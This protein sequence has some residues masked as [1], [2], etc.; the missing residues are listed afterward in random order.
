MLL[1]IDGIFKLSIFIDSPKEN[2][3]IAVNRIGK[4]IYISEIFTKKFFLSPDI[5]DIY[6]NLNISHLFTNFIYGEISNTDGMLSMNNTKLGSS[7]SSSINYQQELVFTFNQYISNLLNIIN[8]LDDN[9][10]FN[11]PSLKSLVNININDN[12]Y[13]N[14]T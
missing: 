9:I 3:L 8:N 13:K 11:N 5:L 10:I 7:R 1:N 2:C 6:N 14:R 12:K 4:I